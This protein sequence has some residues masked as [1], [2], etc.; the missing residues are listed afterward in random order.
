MNNKD[1]DIH[2]V[3]EVPME[4]PIEIEQSLSP[5]LTLTF[6]RDNIKFILLFPVV[7]IYPL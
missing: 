7:V 2:E 5:W 6:H 4:G 3:E 1:V